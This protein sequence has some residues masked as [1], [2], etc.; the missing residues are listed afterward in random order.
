MTPQPTHQPPPGSCNAHCYGLGPFA[1]RL[2]GHAPERI[3]WGTDWSHVNL[4]GL[5]SDD[6]ALFDLIPQIVPSVA[7]QQRM[8]VDKPAELFAFN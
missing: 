6:A 5:A 2:A 3:L 4:D 1:R 8:L 7:L